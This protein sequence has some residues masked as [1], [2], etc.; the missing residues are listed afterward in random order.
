MTMLAGRLLRDGVLQQSSLSPNDAFCAPEKQQALLEL[1]LDV[2]DRCAA[3]VER[4]VP[5][6]R[7]EA[8]DLSSV[9][10]ARDTVAPDDAAAV[11][12]IGTRVL[13][14]LGEVS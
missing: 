8:L 1:V 11:D 13:S 9:T 2:Y 12:A 7:I 3:L 5:A 14:T 6:A 4:G 10:R